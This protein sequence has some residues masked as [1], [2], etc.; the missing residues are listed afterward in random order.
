MLARILA[1][2]A[3]LHTDGGGKRKAAL[4]PIYGRERILRLFEGT[5]RKS[6]AAI[7]DLRAASINGLP[8]FVVTRADGSVH[9]IALE[10]AGNEI[11]ATYAAL[12]P[13][14]LQH[15]P[16]APRDG[17]IMCSPSPVQ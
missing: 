5:A 4:N 10:I 11:K 1:A 17:S 8:E 13:D 3:V 16:G 14:K 12:N 7:A 2:D 15:L 6:P 9:R